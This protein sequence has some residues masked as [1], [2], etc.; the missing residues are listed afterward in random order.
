MRIATDVVLPVFQRDRLRRAVSGTGAAADA[1]II[2]PGVFALC[3]LPYLRYNQAGI[4]ASDSFLRDETS[5]KAK[6]SKSAGIGGMPFR[7]AA[8]RMEICFPFRRCRLK[9]DSES[10]ILA[11]Y[12]GIDSSFFQPLPDPLGS[13][14]TGVRKFLPMISG[15]LYCRNS[16]SPAS[17][18]PINGKSYRSTLLLP[19][20]STVLPLV[21]PKRNRLSRIK[22]SFVYIS[23]TSFSDTGHVICRYMHVAY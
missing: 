15:C 5:R 3:R 12:T 20:I 22:A 2:D 6:G 14:S 23:V 9:A 8:V 4:P 16:S 1:V 10:L 18:N 19:G 7:P 17:A 11:R 13:H 21:S